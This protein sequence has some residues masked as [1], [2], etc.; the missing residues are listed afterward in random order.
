MAGP[1]WN[2]CHLSAC[3]VCTIKP[4][5]SLQWHFI[6]S[7][8]RTVHMCCCN[9]PTAFLAEW[10]GSFTCY[11][12]NTGAEQIPNYESAQKLDHGEENSTAAPAGTSTPLA[13]ESGALPLSYPGSLTWCQWWS[14]SHL[15]ERRHRIFRLTSNCPGTLRS[16]KIVENECLW[17]A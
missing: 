3:S 14:V 17:L 13:H 7:H 8:I 11:Y 6:W 2:C 12:S 4:H 10:L 16:S 1:T 9:L 15:P 5:T